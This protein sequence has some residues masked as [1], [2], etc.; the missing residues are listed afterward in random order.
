MLLLINLH[1]RP[2]I[3]Y[4]SGDFVLTGLTSEVSSA[5]GASGFQP[6]RFPAED[7]ASFH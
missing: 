2:R 6:A 5:G 7:K 3:L 4:R 1:Y